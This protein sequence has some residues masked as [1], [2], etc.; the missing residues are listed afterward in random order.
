MLDSLHN[1]YSKFLPIST[2]TCVY[3]STYLWN[4][5]IAVHAWGELPDK[6]LLSKNQQIFLCT[7]YL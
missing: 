4:A 2:H 6:L 7:E 1:D 3:L 5:Y